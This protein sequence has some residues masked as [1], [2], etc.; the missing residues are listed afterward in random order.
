MAKGKSKPTSTS[1]F[2]ASVCISLANISLA[3]SSNMTKCRVRMDMHSKNRVDSEVWRIEASK[4]TN[5]SH[6]ACYSSLSG[7][8]HLCN[9][10][11][12][13]LRKNF[14]CIKTLYSSVSQDFLTTTHS[15]EYTVRTIWLIS[16]TIFTKYYF[17]P[18]TF[19]FIILFFKLLVA[20]WINFRIP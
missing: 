20:H 5:L 2:H 16:Y 14:D 10:I 18:W 15:K 7:I 12:V 6:R 4:A 19:L 9:F 13:E 11:F 1:L 3:N 17:L 8:I